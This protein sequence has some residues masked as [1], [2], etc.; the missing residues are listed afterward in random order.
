MIRMHPGRWQKSRRFIRGRLFVLGLLFVLGPILTISSSGAAQGPPFGLPLLGE[1]GPSSWFVSQWYGDTIWARRNWPDLYAAGQGLHFGVDFF[2]P[3]G[4]PVVAIGDGTVFAVDGP[5]GSAPHNLVIDHHNGYLS[6][7]G[8]LMQRADV[9]VG[10]VVRRGDV[11]AHTG[12]PTGRCDRA[13][14]LHLEVRRSVMTVAVNPVPLI[15]ADWHTL[16]IGADT[17]GTKFAVDYGH[18]HQWN[19]PAD[20]PDTRFGG[21]IVNDTAN[22]WPPR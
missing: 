15:D 17:D 16:S 5:Y 13:P 12:D 22:G 9:S 20:Q 6:L 10:Q 1:P 2:A 3:C 21:S 18:P 7:Y 14:H 4:T 8:H 11:V 19:V